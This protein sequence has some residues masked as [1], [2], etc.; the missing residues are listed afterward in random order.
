MAVFPSALARE[1]DGQ[2]A[3]DR[4]HRAVQRQL[5]HGEE[6]RRVA[7]LHLA[8]GH[9][10]AQRDGQVEARAFLA[11][12][13]RRQVHHQAHV[14]GELE[15]RVADGRACTRSPASRTAVSGRPT[16]MKCCS[17]GAVSTSTCT[18]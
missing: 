9:E 3:G 17:P 10:D 12:I 15:L 13:R 14:E 16:M 7:A 8:G 1:G 6:A 18:V 2:H 5:A 11:D 4:A